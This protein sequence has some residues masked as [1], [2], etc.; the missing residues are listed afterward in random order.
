MWESSCVRVIGSLFVVGDRELTLEYLGEGDEGLRT[1]EAYGQELVVDDA[2]E[3]VIVLDVHLDKE[4]VLTCGVMTLYYLGDLTEG[5]HYAV[6][7]GGVLEK[8]TE[9]GACLE[10]YLEGVDAKL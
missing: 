1:G 9:I 8:E 10:T 2:T 7:V 4:I 6:I 5:L 3:G